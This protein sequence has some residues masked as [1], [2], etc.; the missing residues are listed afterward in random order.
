MVN[1]ILDINA[2]CN[3]SCKFCSKEIDGSS[4]QINDVLQIADENK[5]EIGISGG[6]PL[7]HPDFLTI[8]RETRKRNRKV[9]VATNL[10]EVPEGLLDLEEEI[11]K[12]TVI[13]VSLHASNPELY[14]QITGRDLYWKVMS[15]L[16]RIST[17][18]RTSIS[19]AVY[20]DN[21]EDV[22]N[23]VNL[24]YEIG[25]PIRVNLV[26]PIGNGR[27]VALL[28]ERQ[29]DQLRGYLLV[30]KLRKGS[31]VDSPLVHRNNCHALSN[32]YGL[33]KFGDCPVDAGSK[34]YFDVHGNKHCCEFLEIQRGK[35]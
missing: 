15:N 25:L 32:Y 22:E 34:V 2:S 30:E 21:Y 28:N 8:L 14:R 17:R 31:L 7:L 11:R 35:K 26:M 6:E 27:K 19:C 24:A 13:Q 23:L 12:D 3:E 20:Q 18:F 5:G 10:T 1:L 9:I 16:D 4:M 29:I 33:E